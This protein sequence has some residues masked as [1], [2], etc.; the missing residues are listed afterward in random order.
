M[1]LL[2]TGTGFTITANELVALNGGTPLSV[3]TVVMTLLVPA[4]DTFG[5]HVMTPVFGLIA[6]TFV[7]VTVLRQ[8]VSQR[9]RR[10]SPHPSPCSSP[11]ADSTDS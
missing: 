1:T 8:H 11:P 10:H 6:G 3:T 5:V 2:S 4:C 7:P 9:L